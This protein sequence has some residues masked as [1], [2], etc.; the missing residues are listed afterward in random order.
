MQSPDYIS[1]TPLHHLYQLVLFTQVMESWIHVIYA[2]F[3]TH[4]QHVRTETRVCQ[5]VCTFSHLI[6][7]IICLL[8]FHYLILSSQAWS[9]SVVHLFQHVKSCCF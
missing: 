5:S 4:H 8:L 6:V 7:M 1:K 3:S 9:S 2:N